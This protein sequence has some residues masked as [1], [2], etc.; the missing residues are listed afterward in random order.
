MTLFLVFF[1]IS[2]ISH[3]SRHQC[4]S[5]HQWPLNYQGPATS[6]ISCRFF[7]N[8]IVQGTFFL[9]STWVGIGGRNRRK[10][11][12]IIFDFF[13]WVV[14]GDNLIQMF[15]KKAFIWQASGWWVSGRYGEPALL[16]PTM[17][18]I[19]SNVTGSNLNPVYKKDRPR[20][21]KHATCSA[22]KA[23]KLLNYKTKTDLITGITKTF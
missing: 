14:D 12:E 15:G 17:V 19:C 9:V 8:V 20:E 13:I 18:E 11:G 16:L 7:L 22:D 5:F 21:V 2:E 23:R 3:S 10:D 4:E 6:K 1:L